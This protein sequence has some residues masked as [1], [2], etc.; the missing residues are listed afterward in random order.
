[1]LDYETTIL[2]VEKAQ[3]NNQEALNTL[4][5]ENSPLIKSIIK[6][7]KNKGVE[8]EDL[9]QIGSLG[10]LK[11]VKNFDKNFNVKFSTYAVPMIAGEIKR[12]LRD[13]GFIKVSRSVKHLNIQINKYI[14]DY[15]AEHYVSPSLN[16]I[17]DYFG[18]SLDYLL[19]RTDNK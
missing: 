17:A 4:V 18:V 12:Y 16:Q 13:S 5:K 11:A 14:E 15:V 10:F 3:N 8:Y 7:Y 9:F 1:M 6:R 19:G 2:L